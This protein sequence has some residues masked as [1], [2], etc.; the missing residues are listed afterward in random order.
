[1]AR[2]LGQG[3]CAQ[4]PARK[5]VWISLRQIFCEASVAQAAPH[6]SGSLQL[7]LDDIHDQFKPVW[8]SARSRSYCAGLIEYNGGIQRTR[9]NL[10]A[11]A[12]PFAELECFGR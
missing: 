1:M 9:K 5:T 3:V 11:A 10:Y 6:S 8:K 4:Y 7:R 12:K 2:I